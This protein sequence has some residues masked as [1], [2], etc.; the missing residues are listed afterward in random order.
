VTDNDAVVSIRTNG[1]VD[2]SI[3]MG[4]GRPT[5]DQPTQVLS[6][7][8]PLLLHLTARRAANI[9]LGSGVTSHVMLGDPGLELVDTIEIEA[10]MIEG[11]RSFSPRNERVF[12]DP[13]SR[14]VVDDAKSFFASQRLAYDVIV[15]EP[16]NPWVSGTASLFTQEFYELVRRHLA[17]DGLFVQWLQLYE[18]DL[19]LVASVLKALG[20]QFA[21]YAI[22]APAGGD[23]L[24]VAVNGDQVP[25][26]GERSWPSGLSADL[27]RVSI[28]TPEDITRRKVAN[29]RTLEPWLR[30]VDIRPNSDYRPTLDH[31]A[32]RARFLGHEALALMALG[33]GRL[34]ISELVGG[35]RRPAAS[36]RPT[37][38]G[39]LPTSPQPFLAMDIRDRLA[40]MRRGENPSP[41]S[42]VDLSASE[43]IQA[44][45]VGPDA[46]GETAIFRLGSSLAAHLS[47]QELESVWSDLDALPCVTASGGMTPIWVSLFR[48]VA[49]RDP[50]SIAEEAEKLLASRL[51]SDEQRLYAAEA[52]VLGNVAVGRL[53]QARSL[54]RSIRTPGSGA[55]PSFSLEV[56]AAHA[57][58]TTR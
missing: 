20:Q 3:N 57:E 28:Q 2:A 48:S 4:G 30:Q 14:I 10:A 58:R 1:K 15:S 12:T 11:A 7:A 50:A 23:L 6:G 31:R 47:P 22:Y 38:S 46:D 39:I 45:K 17:R 18:F 55:L 36:T 54:L 9:G 44:C 40:D 37:R 43:M 49:R 35:E 41:T 19:D 27:R 29:R 26:L 25:E 52:G 53:D 56:L 34:P 32:V 5:G 51:A 16:S 33:S 42:R 13:R 8:L 21:D 24:I